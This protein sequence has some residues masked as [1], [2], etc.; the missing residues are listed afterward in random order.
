MAKPLE[1]IRVLDIG[2]L[3]AGP[4]GAT[5]LGDFGAEV[6]KVEQPDTGDSLRGAPKDGEPGTPLNWLIDSRNKKSITLNLRSSKGQQMT[7]LTL[8]VRMPISRGI[9]S[10]MSVQVILPARGAQMRFPPHRVPTSPWCAT[11]STA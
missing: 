2:T 9:S 4:W 1:G 11:F 6:I 8:T 3:L 7:A 10:G 5:L